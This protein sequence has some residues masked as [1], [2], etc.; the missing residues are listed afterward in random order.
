M[1][2]NNCLL[3]QIDSDHDE[4]S[5]LFGT[6]HIKDAKA[7][8]LLEQLYSRLDLCE[9]FATEINLDELHSAGVGM[10]KLSPTPPLYSL[11]PSKK[12]QKLR[13]I[14]KKALAIDLDRWA[15][16]HPMIINNM[17]TETILSNEM[18]VFLDD[19]LWRYAKTKDKKLFGIETIEEQFKLM[20]GLSIKEHL[21]NLQQISKNYTRFR[22]NLLKMLDYYSR[23]DLR[24]LHKSALKGAGKM[25]QQMIYD[26]NRIM[27]E[28]IDQLIQSE[29]TA[30]CA[31][32][33]GH[34]AGEKGVLRLLKHKN[35]KLTPVA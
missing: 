9:A 3:W 19:H 5:W 32:G 10:T 14:L 12:Y 17:I 15:P 11:L 4:P 6:M 16:L 31:I 8:G 34:L 2:K 33:A 29:K 35:Y 30:F 27:A 18:P 22:K 21:D 26:R 25:K 7:F 13:K 24:S 20:Q 1:K 28:R 23:G